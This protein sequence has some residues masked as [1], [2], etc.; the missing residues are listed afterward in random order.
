MAA[1]TAAQRRRRPRRRI[2]GSAAPPP[3]H[4]PRRPDRRAGRRAAGG[5]PVTAA[6]RRTGRRGRST[7]SPC[8]T[9]APPTRAVPA[10]EPGGA[11]SAHTD[12]DYR[13]TLLPAFRSNHVPLGALVIDTDYTSPSTWDGWN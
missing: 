7:A 1:A 5:H 10:A 2:T 12:A 9:P 6:A 4:L 13:D 3:P 11:S 8:S